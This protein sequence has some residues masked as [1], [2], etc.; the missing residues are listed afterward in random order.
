MAAYNG[1]A[2]LAEQLQSIFDQSVVPNEIVICDDGSTDDTREILES[3]RER[4]P[5]VIRVYRNERNLGVSGNFEKAISLAAGDFIFLSDQDDVWH[6]EKVERLLGLLVDSDQPSGAFCDSRVVDGMLRPLGSTHRELRGFGAGEPVA[7]LGTF[8]KR[9]P[10]AGHNMAFDARLKELLLPF[11]ALAECHDSW[12]GLVLAALGAWR[13]TDECL[14]DFR[15]HEGNV[16]NSGQRRTWR[17]KLAEARRSV[18][19]NTF[20]WNAR[21]YG[22]LLERVGGLCPPETAALLED[23]RKHSEARARMNTSFFK[24][25]PLIAGEIRLRRYFRYGRGWQNVFQDLFLR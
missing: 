15:Q 9:V 20:D 25:L 23:R 19:S 2:Y 4:Y 21:L 22:A 11:P 18:R 3:F 12:I 24:R 5:D 6:P 10:A 16:S 17:G 13:A 8:L 14:T 1:G 7:A